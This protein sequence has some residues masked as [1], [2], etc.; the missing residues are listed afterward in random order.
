MTEKI[1]KYSKEI[2]YHFSCSECKNWWSYALSPNTPDLKPVKSFSCPHCG[3][4]Y[5]QLEE[6][7][8]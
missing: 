7:N 3:I 5:K 2:L 4:R 6:I 1:L 8:V